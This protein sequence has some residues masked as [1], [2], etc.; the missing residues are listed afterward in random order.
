MAELE[1]S[2]PA[3]DLA[4]SA[5]PEQGAALLE[6]QQRF[7]QVLEQIGAE[8]P[9]RWLSP[10]APE[11]EQAYVLGNQGAPAGSSDAGVSRSPHMSGSQQRP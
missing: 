4:G 7:G 8:N 11:R 3:T 9:P 10:V 2:T 6:Q 5:A 1:G